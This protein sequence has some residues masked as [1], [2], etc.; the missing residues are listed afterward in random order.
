MARDRGEVGLE[1]RAEDLEGPAQGRPD[2]LSRPVGREQ[3]R[4]EVGVLPADF[5]DREGVAANA[6]NAAVSRGSRWGNALLGLGEHRAVA[7]VQRVEV[8]QLARDPAAVLR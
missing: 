6:R 5:V 7:G 4:W 1:Q 2:Q 3:R 8:P